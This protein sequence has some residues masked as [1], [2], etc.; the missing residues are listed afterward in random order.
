MERLRP[1]GLQTETAV[2]GERRARACASRLQS[3]VPLTP[4]RPQAASGVLP[5]RASMT[6]TIPHAPTHPFGLFR[7]FPDF[8]SGF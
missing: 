6:A 7:T 5:R 2:V 3:A 1:Q 8:F 4:T